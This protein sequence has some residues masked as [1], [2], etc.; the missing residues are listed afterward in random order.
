MFPI[1][2][3]VEL[4]HDTFTNKNVLFYS[5]NMAV[6]YII[7]QQTSKDN[8]IMRLVRRLVVNCLKFNILFQAKH[9]PGMNNTLADYLSRQQIQE[10]LHTSP[11][12]AHQQAMVP[13]ASLIL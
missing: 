7:N 1:V 9:I 8:M 6:V 3:A 13:A 12:L 5:D 4:F 10:F 11:F 2:L